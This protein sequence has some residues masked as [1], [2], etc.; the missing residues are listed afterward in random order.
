MPARLAPTVGWRGLAALLAIFLALIIAPL[1]VW[2]GPSGQEQFAANC[3]ACHRL[4][5]QGAPGVFPALAGNAF[6]QQPDPRAVVTVVL[7]GRGGMPSFKADL[8]DGQIAA[9]LSYVRSAWG[10]QASPVAAPLVAAVRAQAPPAPARGLQ[11]H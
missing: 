7:K 6:V 3:S 10:N 4:T 8:D 9:I 5:G 11:S 2:A 1:P